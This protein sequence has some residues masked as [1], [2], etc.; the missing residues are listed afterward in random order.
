MLL[1]FTDYWRLLKDLYLVNLVIR[2]SV[3]RYG[4]L[5][6]FCY[7]QMM[8]GHCAR[9]LSS[10]AEFCWSGEWNNICL[11]CPIWWQRLITRCFLINYCYVFM[12]TVKN[13]RI[14]FCHM[15]V[16]SG[17]K[18]LVSLQKVFTFCPCCFYVILMVLCFLVVICI[19]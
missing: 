10:T 16:F 11:F 13:K 18:T 17:R 3:L 1:F 9:A 5:P 15:V 8:V 14:F 12:W 4:W 19:C 7:Y 6:N 2:S